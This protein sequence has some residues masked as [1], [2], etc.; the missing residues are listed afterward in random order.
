[1]ELRLFALSHPWKATPLSLLRA[2]LNLNGNFKGISAIMKQIAELDY[3][4]N[5]STQVIR[6]RNQ[7]T[8]LAVLV[9]SINARGGS[10]VTWT[11]EFL[12]SELE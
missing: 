4:E 1:M 11:N 10:M 7:S 3:G 2:Y 12:H 9:L 6:Q 5:R 8:S